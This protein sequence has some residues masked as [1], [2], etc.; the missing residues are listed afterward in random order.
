MTF[1]AYGRP[2]AWVASL[3]DMGALM[4][5]SLCWV[6]AGFLSLCFRMRMTMMTMVT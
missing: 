5:I 6:E 1:L 2:G 4:P 3:P